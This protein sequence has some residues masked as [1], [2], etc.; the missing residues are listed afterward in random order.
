MLYMLYVTIKWLYFCYEQSYVY[1]Y[2]TLFRSVSPAIDPR[3]GSLC[4]T[5]FPCS[6]REWIPVWRF[7]LLS[8]TC[9]LGYAGETWMQINTV[10]RSYMYGLVKNLYCNRYEVRT[11]A[12]TNNSLN[13]VLVLMKLHCKLWYAGVCLERLLM[14]INE[15][16]PISYVLKD[17]IHVFMP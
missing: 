6:V 13:I 1:Y 2:C 14:S 11:N 9:T 4:Y 3:L 7:F 17:R 5:N 8:G 10:Q 12:I 16:S 15:R